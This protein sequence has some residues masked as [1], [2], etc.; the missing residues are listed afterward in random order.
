MTKPR[1]LFVCQ[2]CGAQSAKWLGRC[3]DCGAWNSLVEERAVE[4]GGV[5]PGQHRYA[6]AGASTVAHQ[7]LGYAT[8]TPVKVFI[9]RGGAWAVVNPSDIRR[10]GGWTVLSDSLRRSGGWTPLSRAWLYN[11]RARLLLPARIEDAG[12]PRRL[13]IAA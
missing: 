7:I 9:R 6:M 12:E 5:P 10:S 3:A 2:E 4:S 8:Y 13:G 1:S 11:R